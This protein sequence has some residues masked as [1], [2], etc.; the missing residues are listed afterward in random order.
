MARCPTLS[1]RGRTSPGRAVHV[2]D[3]SGRPDRDLFASRRERATVAWEWVVGEDNEM[4]GGGVAVA[5][6]HL[7]PVVK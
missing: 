7:L 5:E 1:V 4:T 2:S 3:G 6:S